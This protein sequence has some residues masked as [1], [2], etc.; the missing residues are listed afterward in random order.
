MIIGKVRGSVVATRKNEKLVGHKFLVVE[1]YERIAK[2]NDYLIA[3]DKIGAGIGDFVLITTGSGA[4][5]AAGDVDSP[6][7]A[8]VV[9]I[10]DE[11][12][13]F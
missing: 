8:A 11:E 7:D 3:V 9:G 6:I 12:P 13:Q 5:L 4:R 10:L 2:N 1:L